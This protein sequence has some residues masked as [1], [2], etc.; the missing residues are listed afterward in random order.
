MSKLCMYDC[1]FIGCW[2][3]VEGRRI[4]RP[5]H[6]GIRGNCDMVAYTFHSITSPVNLVISHRTS[7]IFSVAGSARVISLAESRP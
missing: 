1:V 2:F 3:G 7:K 6:H 5:L 4:D